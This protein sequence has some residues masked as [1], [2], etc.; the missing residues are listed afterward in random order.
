MI[1]T[2]RNRLGVRPARLFPALLSWQPQQNALIIGWAAA[3]R[4]WASSYV[5]ARKTLEVPK[6][7]PVRFTRLGLSATSDR[8]ELMEQPRGKEAKTQ[9]SPAQTKK[10]Q[11]GPAFDILRRRKRLALGPSHASPPGSRRW[12]WACSG[13]LTRSYDS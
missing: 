2:G 7:A 11:M 5:C 8:P 3:P 12:R 9:L 10:G 4:N 13:T 6:V 1:K